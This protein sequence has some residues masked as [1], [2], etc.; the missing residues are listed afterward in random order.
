MAKLVKCVDCGGAISS[1]AIRCPHC[2]ALY[3]VDTLIS[4]IE[5]KKP[6]RS[7][8]SRCPH[9][10]TE[11]PRGAECIVCTEVV[12]TSQGMIFKSKFLH[13]ECYDAITKECKY[14][15]PICRKLI[16]SYDVNSCPKCGHPIEHEKCEYC[17][18]TLFKYQAVWRDVSYDPP[19]EWHYAHKACSA[20]CKRGLWKLSKLFIRWLSSGFRVE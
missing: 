16:T 10:K 2:N 12:R 13:K 11:Y 6:M 5:C 14:S 3:P 8:V 1:A 17:E 18:G 9:C 19:S 4:C 20:G 7:R 15:C